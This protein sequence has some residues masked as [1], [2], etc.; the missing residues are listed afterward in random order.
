MSM[1]LKFF[2][3]FIPLLR[4]ALKNKIFWY[5]ASRYMVL[6]IQFLASIFLAIKLGAYN[7]G[8]WSFIL[9]LVHIGTSFNW[10]IGNAATILLVQHKE[11]KQKCQDYIFNSMILTVLISILPCVVAAY[12]RILGIALFDKYHLGNKIYIV[13]FLIVAS[14]FSSLLMNISRVKN[15]IG[16]ITVAQMLWPFLMCVT[17]FCATEKALLFSLL[18][19]YV[20]ASGIGLAIYLL[21]RQISFSGHF[22]TSYLREIFIKGFFLFLYNA[23]F[24]FIV[25]S[26]KTIVGKYYSVEEFSYFSFA[27]SLAY[28]IMLLIDSLLFI[29][30]HKMVEM[31]R[32]D[33]REKISNTLKFMRRNYLYMLHLLFYFVLAASGI[34]VVLFP[35]YAKSFDSFILIIFSL[36]MHSYCFG[37]NTYLLAQNKEKQMALFTGLALLFNIAAAL[38]LVCVL[39]CKFS[40]VILA[41][42][43]TYGIYSA[44]VN[45]YALRVAGLDK[46]WKELIR[47]IFIP[48]LTPLY[49]ITLLLVL[50]QFD[51]RYIFLPLIAFLL[52]NM[53]ELKNIFCNISQ[54]LN[55]KKTNI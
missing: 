38:V 19:V 31:L 33:D 36:T 41:T 55:N 5:L 45:W 34:F 52:L 40:Y 11:D 6:G 22:S 28:G 49:L 53:F 44:V 32:G 10:G 37:Y 35:K 21:P 4:S 25:L 30:F 42:L 8:V 20:I 9:L 26:T 39:Q 13:V 29:I 12:D 51:K 27:F 23:G 16:E 3:T 47:S 50:L 15:R 17:L 2:N 24:S 7:F 48:R 1:S 46:S 54:M 18:L 14:Y 43:L